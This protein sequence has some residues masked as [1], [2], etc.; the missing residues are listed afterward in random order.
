MGK[1]SLPKDYNVHILG[2]G[3]LL[4]FTAFNTAS[5]IEAIV[6]KDFQ[7]NGIKSDTGFHCLAILY[8]CFAFTS[9]IAPAIVGMIG[10]K[11]CLVASGLTYVGFT[12]TLYE[13]HL[14]SILALS[15]INGAGAAVLWTA[16]GVVTQRL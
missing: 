14:I 9:W 1:L 7:R 15:A 10:C 2:L 11:A 5:M 6:L 13:P 12:M 8:T 16:N 3:F 4:V